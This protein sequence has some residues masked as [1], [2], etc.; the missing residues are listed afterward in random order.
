MRPNDL[1]KRLLVTFLI[2]GPLLFGASFVSPAQEPR[3]D[4]KPA[5][6]KPRRALP[7]EAKEWKGDFDGMLKRRIFAFWFP[8]AGRLL[9]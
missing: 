7:T 8:T 9:Q 1:V 2:A 3:A 5:P 6:A 4:P